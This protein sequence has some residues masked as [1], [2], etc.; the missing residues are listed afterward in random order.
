MK[1]S[2][3]NIICGLMLA[4]LAMIAVGCMPPKSDHPYTPT[5]DEA[6]PVPPG[7]RII[8]FGHYPV[9]PFMIPREP[10]SLYV[11]DDDVHKTAYMAAISSDASSSQMTDLNQI[12]KNSFDPTHNYRVYFVPAPAATTQPAVS[13]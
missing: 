8:A 2:R 10:G 4:T 6:I 11:W 12:S 5:P 13:Q 1:P 9:G 3:S 7:A